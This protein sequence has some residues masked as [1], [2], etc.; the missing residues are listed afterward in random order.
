[1]PK[2]RVIIEMRTPVANESPVASVLTKYVDDTVFETAGKYSISG[3]EYM[4][5]L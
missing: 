2:A 4:P 5:Y 1:M 3:T